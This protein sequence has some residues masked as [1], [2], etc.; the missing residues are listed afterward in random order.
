MRHESSVTAISWIPSDAV[1]GPLRLPM[2]L[3]VGRYDDPPPDRIAGGD[4]EELSAANRI[5]FANV[6]RGWAEVDSGRVVAYGTESRTYLGRTVVHVG[7]RTVAF[8]AVPYPDLEPE[9]E[10]GSHG[11]RFMR[12]AG[13]RTGVPLPRR[14]DRPPFVRVVAPPAWST[15]SLTIAPDGGTEPTLAGASP[16]P[17][18][19]VYDGHG[20]LVAKSGTTD[21]R[22]W[23]RQATAEG[24]RTPWGDDD[25]EAVLV[26]AETALERRL[27]AAIMRGRPERRRFE[28]GAVLVEQGQP[29]REVYLLL[30]G[31]VGVEVD[32]GPVTEVGPGAIV[33]ER[34]LLED[35]TRTAT[36]RAVTACRVAVVGADQLDVDA[37]RRL[38]AGHRREDQP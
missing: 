13:A 14:I 12:T 15:L 25:A 16:F 10:V 9:P 31:V 28:A 11:V 30:D 26:A 38:A 29:G 1:E 18:H 35:G 2:D 32:G 20:N 19:W 21:W 34:A 22:E 7:S 4:L 24:E 27:S 8:E 17:R 3:G 37:L 33:G 36:L 23:T 6:L 5:R